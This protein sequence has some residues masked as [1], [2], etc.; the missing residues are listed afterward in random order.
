M[1]QAGYLSTEERLNSSGWQSPRTWGGA[2]Q[3]INLWQWQGPADWLRPQL[4]EHD[5]DVRKRGDNGSNLR[6]LFRSEVPRGRSRNLAMEGAPENAVEQRHGSRYSLPF[7]SR[8][9]RGGR[10][11]GTILNYLIL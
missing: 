7:V 4:G 2:R 11:V 1:Y 3:H 10:F 5:F 8:R 9:G 6:R